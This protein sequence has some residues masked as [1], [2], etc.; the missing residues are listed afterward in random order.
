MIYV[1]A[2]TIG[3]SRDTANEVILAGWVIESDITKRW[4]IDPKKWC[5]PVNDLRDMEELEQ[6]I[7]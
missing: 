3:K 2:F 1:A 5:V 7:R 6:Y 4:N